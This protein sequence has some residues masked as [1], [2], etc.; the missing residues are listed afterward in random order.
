M[1]EPGYATV[2][3]RPLLK[4]YL[5][6]RGSR[7]E[8]RA[9][10][11]WAFTMV[12]YV[13]LALAADSR[14]RSWVSPDHRAT[15]SSVKLRRN[16]DLGYQLTLMRVG[17]APVIVDEYLRSVDVLWSADSKYVAITDWIGSNV[18]DCLVVDT[19]RPE[20]KINVATMLPKIQEDI[21]NS[22]FY[23]SCKRWNGQGTIA[24][25]AAGHTDYPPSHDFKYRFVLDV[26]TGHVQAR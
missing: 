15:L 6:P 16:D 3:Q 7:G 19:T 17:R 26:P 20:K 12:A 2:C 11:A 4:C 22:H 23:V 18:A 21:P 10:A 5:G 8:A 9:V 1:K 24:V 25:E 13:P 14:V